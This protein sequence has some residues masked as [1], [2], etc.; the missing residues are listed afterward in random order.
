M[1]GA[2]QTIIGSNSIIGRTSSCLTSATRP[3]HADAINA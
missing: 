3:P 1:S 2:S